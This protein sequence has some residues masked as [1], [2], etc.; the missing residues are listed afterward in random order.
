MLVPVERT[1]HHIPAGAHFR[2]FQYQCEEHARGAICPKGCHEMGL[3]AP[4]SA[5]TICVTTIA[6]ESRPCGHVGALSPPT[7]LIEADQWKCCSNQ[8][9]WELIQRKAPMV[10]C[11]RT[12]TTAPKIK[13]SLRSLSPNFR[14]RGSFN[15][16][17]GL[18]LRGF[19]FDR[20]ISLTG[21]FRCWDFPTLAF[22]EGYCLGMAL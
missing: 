20:Y 17:S 12:G 13:S 14:F 19:F 11:N 5:I 18:V 1:T 22:G 16:G 7:K 3:L 8:I 4:R 15:A 10:Y 6:K 2:S 9:T 21:A